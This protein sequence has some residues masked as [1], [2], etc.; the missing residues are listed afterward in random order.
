MYEK[1]L[2]VWVYKK[3]KIQFQWDDSSM[4]SFCCSAWYHVVWGI[5]L[6]ILGQLPWSRPVP[7]SCAPQLLAVRAVHK[8]GKSLTQYKPGSAPS[9]TLACYQRF[10]H[11]K[12]KAPQVPAAVRQKINPVPAKTNTWEIASKKLKEREEKTKREILEIN[13]EWVF[14]EFCRLRIGRKDV[15][16]MLVKIASGF[17]NVLL[18]N[19][20]AD[21][22]G[23]VVDESLLP[24]HYYGLCRL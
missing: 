16:E 14:L 12:S 3:K 6:A 2:K 10:S 13:L 20:V 23:F 11:P 7:A 22:E 21:A 19:A 1:F 24:L 9:Q 15:M 18:L 8:A 5:S 4:L 17:R